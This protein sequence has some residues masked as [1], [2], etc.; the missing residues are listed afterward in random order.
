MAINLF[1]T[2]YFN[3]LIFIYTFFCLKCILW[4]VCCWFLW[5]WLINRKYAEAI[6]KSNAAQNQKI[7]DSFS[8]IFYYTWDIN[9]TKHR[10][11]AW[12]MPIFG[13]YAF[14]IKDGD[15]SEAW[16]YFDTAFLLF[17]WVKHQ[18]ILEYPY[19]IFAGFSSSIFTLNIQKEVRVE[20]TG[21]NIVFR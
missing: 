3:F 8:E 19:N 16:Y 21:G 15:L 2:R 18:I 13:E 5:L 1:Y 7:V 14:S 17:T 20:M 4:T 9:N 6:K 11:C 10:N 12:A